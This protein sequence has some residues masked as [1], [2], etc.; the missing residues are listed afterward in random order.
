MALDRFIYF[1]GDVP[2]Y[3]DI[4]ELCVLYVG[5]SGTIELDPPRIFA[6]FPGECISPIYRPEKF[7]EVFVAQDN[8]DVMTRLA[9]PSTNKLAD[10]LANVIADKFK[11]K[12][13]S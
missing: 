3:D 1:E 12:R 6:V 10:Q 4:R 5:E 2:S 11:G 7:I 8:V 9:D 13:E